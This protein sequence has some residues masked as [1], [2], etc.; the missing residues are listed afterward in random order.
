M[1]YLIGHEAGHDF[2]IQ[3][4]QRKCKMTRNGHKVT[5]KTANNE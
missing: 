3:K 1:C 2:G 5:I 4:I